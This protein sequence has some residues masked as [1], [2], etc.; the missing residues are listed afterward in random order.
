[1]YYN[2]ILRIWKLD[3]L[4]YFLL[5]AIVGSLLASRTKKYLSEKKAMERLKSSIIKKS[6]LLIK[7]K[8]T[9]LNSKKT[10]IKKIYIVALDNRGGQLENFQA[11]HELS[12]EAFKYAQ[13]IKGL[14]ERLA[15]YL[16]KRELQGIARIFF[17]NGRLILELLLY[18]CNINVSYAFLTE[19][20]NVK[21]I[22]RN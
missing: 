9:I 6:K 14:V 19:G 8:T 15:S 5:G 4:D 22:I 20:L 3:Q 2:R 11:D 17:K 7:T 13:E 21:L 16:K 10:R 12:N 18:T 1:M